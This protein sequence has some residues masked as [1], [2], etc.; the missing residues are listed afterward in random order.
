MPLVAG[1]FALAL[2]VPAGAATPTTL[3]AGSS[4]DGVDVSGLDSAGATARV[5]GTLAPVLEKP[6]VIRIGPKD[7]QVATADLG[8]K[9]DY[10][11]MVSDAFK[12]A[13][14]HHAVHVSL[15]R[16]TDG[17]KLTSTLTRL[18]KPYYRAPR[19]SRVVLGV[20]AIKRIHGR[21]GKGLASRS[22][23]RRCSTS[24]A[25]TRPTG[26]SP[27]AWQHPPGR[28]AE[29][30]RAQVLHLRVGGPRPLQAAPVQAAAPS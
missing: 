29:D 10:A 22:C 4:I 12:E 13:A 18:G 24:C 7:Q 25:T 9:I 27:A 5:Q 3:P 28:D 1:L 30:A 8:Q 11:G 26:S 23:A 15:E 20:R 2:A 19:N 6:L 17:K 16:R 21:N 14:R